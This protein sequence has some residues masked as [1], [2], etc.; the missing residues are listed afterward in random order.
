MDVSY[1]VYGA[2][3][4]YA[5]DSA[6]GHPFVD[7]DAATLLEDVFGGADKDAGLLSLVRTL[8]LQKKYWIDRDDSAGGVAHLFGVIAE[9]VRTGCVG[10]R[11]AKVVAV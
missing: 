7:D 5:C 4:P 11:V 9:H 2:D 3:E 1:W 6:G 8:W 10:Q